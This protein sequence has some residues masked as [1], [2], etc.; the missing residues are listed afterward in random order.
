MAK[1]VSVLQEDVLRVE[2]LKKRYGRVEALRGLS[3][4][5]PRGAFFG[6]FGRNG[7]G[8]T[9]T[10]DIVTGL[11]ARDS[12]H[13]T[14][15]GE[16]LNVELPSEAKA[17]LGYVA[18]HLQLHDWMTCTEHIEVVSKFY[19][20]WDADRE[21]Q[22]LRMFRLPPDRRVGALSTGQYFGLQLVMAL[23]RHP[24]LLLIDE[25][26][27]LDAVVRQRLLETMIEAIAD[28]EATVL[29]ASHIISEL[30]GVCDHLCIIEGGVALA[31]GPV[32]ELVHAARRVHYRGVRS[33]LLDSGD[34]EAGLRIEQR[35]DGVR[36]LLPRY[37]PQQA[38]A[39]GRQF[40][41]G[42]FDV[43]PLGL[44]EL[45]VALTEARE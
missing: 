41:A 7:A 12:G 10:L 35:A 5:V 27:N 29:M 1:A 6:F 8:K 38:E 24:E 28:Q 39:L 30:E 18:G 21:R 16:G 15:L 17:R 20:T 43:E 37:T 34:V 32:E 9:T 2:N 44:Q 4:G 19:P 14:I 33:A 42:D 11:L 23:S 40:G 3:F 45:F 25:P 31:S 13:V 22:L 26:G 36:V